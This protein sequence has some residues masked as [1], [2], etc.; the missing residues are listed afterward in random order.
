[1]NSFYQ[2]SKVQWTIYAGDEQCFSADEHRL[3]SAASDPLLRLRAR[4][5][6]LVSPIRSMASV[7]LISLAH[8]TTR[9]SI[10]KANTHEIMPDSRKAI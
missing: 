3:D 5:L 4:S 10:E 6:R 1:M 8:T 7:E 2:Q 9:Q